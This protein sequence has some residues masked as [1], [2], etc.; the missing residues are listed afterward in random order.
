[1]TVN[2]ELKN[3][4]IF[5]E[6]LEEKAIELA[7]CMGLSDRIVYS[8]FNHHSMVKVRELEP[9][10]KVAFLYADGIADIEEYGEKYEVYAVHP[11]MK[12]TEYPDMVTKCHAKGIRVHVWTVNEEVDIKHM[13]ELGVDAIITNYVER[14]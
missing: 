12:N 4:M 5:Y 1:M 6:R 2:L 8:S 9:A 13:K 3:S 11:Y 14:G 7:Q 10:A